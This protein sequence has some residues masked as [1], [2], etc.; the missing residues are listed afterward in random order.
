VS[1]ARDSPRSPPRR[2]LSPFSFL[3]TTF[4]RQPRAALWL[5]LVLVALRGPCGSLSWDEYAELVHIHHIGAVV[6][7]SGRTS[8][9]TYV[10]WR[11]V[12]ACPLPKLVHWKV[13]DASRYA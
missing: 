12:D 6:H 1:V 5:A 3:P 8:L 7:R 10:I 2:G 9:G 13:A 4:A 11:I